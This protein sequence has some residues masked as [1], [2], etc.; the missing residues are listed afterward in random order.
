MQTRKEPGHWETDLLES[1]RRDRNALQVC[2]ERKSR[3]ARLEKINNKSADTSRGALQ[4][5]LENYPDKL[6]RTI[7]YDNGKENVEHTLLNK[8]LNMKSYFCQPYHSWE[9]GSVE[10]INGL[11][12]RFL[13]KKTILANI[14]DSNIK[15][16][17]HWLNNRPKKCLNFKTPKEV[18]D[19]FVALA[20]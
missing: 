3:L 19:S 6:R 11:I 5:M 16:I 7:T 12:R 14:S 10:N 17:E 20:P 15:E 18:F 4:N 8:D 2:V 1:V 9:K 13:P